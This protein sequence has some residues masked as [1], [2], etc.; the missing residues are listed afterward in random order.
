MNG[1]EYDIPTE[2]LVG[3]VQVGDLVTIWFNG[4]IQ[5]TDPAQLGMVYR[6][7]KAE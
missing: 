4:M 1:G 5:E 6:V 2:N 3:D 7:I